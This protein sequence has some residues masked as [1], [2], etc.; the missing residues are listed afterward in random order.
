MSAVRFAGFVA[1]VAVWLSGAA[2]ADAQSECKVDTDCEKGLIC[3]VTAISSCPGTATPTPASPALPADC[4]AGTCGAKPAADP[5]AVIA[6]CTPQEYRSCVPGP[7]MSDSDCGEGLVCHERRRGSCVTAG[8]PA[9][10][11]GFKCPEM[12]P[13]KPVCTETVDHICVPR[14]LLPCEQATECGVGFTCEPQDR[15]GCSGSSMGG[16][17]GAAASAPVKAPAQDAGVP[18]DPDASVP[19]PGAADRA[20]VPPPDCACEPTPEKYCKVIETACKQ[21]SDCPNLW[22]CKPSPIAIA[23]T[24]P[25]RAPCFVPP[26]DGGTCGGAGPQPPV[27]RCEPPYQTIDVDSISS[28]RKYDEIPAMTPNTAPTNPTT[29]PPPPLGVPTSNPGAGT[30]GQAAGGNGTAAQPEAA[31]TPPEASKHV[32]SC[33]VATPGAAGGTLQ[34][35][36]TLVALAVI[37]RAR[38]RN[39]RS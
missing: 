30:P 22:T 27:Y 7:C 28:G 35:W 8:A 17:G 9:C 14:S 21:D 18:A 12:T 20:F 11:P 25:A 33:T 36:V 32:K 10:E 37:E 4:D 38:R 2:N 19:D 16:A 23:A 29:N 26:G 3:Q 24:A 13:P 6:P 15:C 5:P 1:A 39:R 34:I 31:P